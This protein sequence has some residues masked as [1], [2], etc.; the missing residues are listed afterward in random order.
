MDDE[1]TESYEDFWGAAAKPMQPR[2]GTAAAITVPQGFYWGPFMR[3]VQ[4]SGQELNAEAGKAF[5][6][7]ALMEWYQA[8]RGRRALAGQDRR[9]ELKRLIPTPAEGDRHARITASLEGLVRDEAFS[10]VVGLRFGATEHGKSLALREA[11]LE[12]LQ[13]VRASMQTGAPAEGE[14]E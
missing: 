5:A 9:D 12:R 13:H 7:D 3:G 1:V 6:R 4:A 10:R 14:E 2:V 11:I 8:Y